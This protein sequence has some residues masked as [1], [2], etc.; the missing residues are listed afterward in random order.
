MKVTL[1]LS[2]LV[3]QGKITPAEAERLKALAA[4]ETG[5]LGINILIGFGVM[6]VAAGAVALVPT[7]LTAVAIGIALFAAG[8]AIEFK[9][10]Q[11][12]DILGQICLV[13]GAL[14]FAGGV[15]AHDKGSLASMLIV[16]VAFVAGA[17][18][19]RSSLLMALAVLAVSACLGA[20]TGYSHAMYSLAIF[21]P[22]ITV[23]LFAGLALG[24]YPGL[25]AAYRRLRAACDH[26]RAHLGVP[27]QFRL[28]DRFALGRQ[29]DPAALAEP[30]RPQP[31]D[32]CQDHSGLG[33]QR[34]LGGGADRRRR[35]GGARQPPLAGQRGGGVRRHPFLHPV[36]RAAGRQSG[37]GAA[38]RPADAGF[39]FAICGR[40]IAGRRAAKASTKA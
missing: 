34:R 2:K 8:L 15:I 13:V 32:Q 37:F 26:R 9:R 21:E 31:I 16:T 28:L 30:Q 23:V 40:S 35:L 36:V 38:R 22:A 12:W 29:P 24:A 3:E 7:P 39:A 19:A 25:E 18:V 6:A 5:S 1:D 14:M 20:R 17:I 27:G 10:G 11:Q 33:L 4:Q